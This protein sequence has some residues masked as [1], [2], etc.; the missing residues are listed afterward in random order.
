MILWFF[1][2]FFF[3]HNSGHYINYI[4]RIH[5][6]GSKIQ[7]RPRKIRTLCKPVYIGVYCRPGCTRHLAVII[8]DSDSI[9]KQRISS[10]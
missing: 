10:Q 4:F 5:G 6:I 1:I 9:S 3:A 2:M 8:N 7:V